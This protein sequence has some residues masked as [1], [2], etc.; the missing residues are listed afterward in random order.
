MITR[1]RK[2]RLATA[3]V[4]ATALALALSGCTGD[5]NPGLPSGF[6]ST[7]PLHAGTVS[8]AKTHGVG[9]QRTWSFD[10]KVPGTAL[11]DIEHQLVQDHWEFEITQADGLVDAHLT[12]DD[13]TY[14]MDLA[15]S[16]TAGR[17][18]YDVRRGTQRLA[19]PK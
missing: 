19:P 10:V 13:G 2:S 14:V 1:G 11:Q 5:Q 16:G 17:A 18:H 4:A 3:A 12:A 8:N 15:V 9:A 7:V 6:P